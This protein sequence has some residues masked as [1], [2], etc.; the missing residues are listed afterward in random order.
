MQ[1]QLPKFKIFTASTLLMK[2]AYLI[3]VTAILFTSC[4]ER[5]YSGGGNHIP[6]LAKAKQV[7]FGGGFH[8]TNKASG[9]QVQ[10]AI[11]ASNRL[12]FMVNGHANTVNSRHTVN[13]IA[14]TDKSDAYYVEGATGFFIP[15]S[16]NI[17]ETY[18]GYGYGSI[19]NSFEDNFAA[20][21][22]NRIFLQPS[23]SILSP[24]GS[25]VFSFSLRLS[26]VNVQIANASSGNSNNVNDYYNLD[27][28]RKKPNLF[29]LEPSFQYR[30]GKKHQGM[31]Q[32]TM[33]RP[34][35]A[36]GY[37]YDGFN[38]GVGYYTSLN[39]K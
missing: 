24:G 38:I 34:V 2:Q 19:R 29:F 18:G 27:L 5:Y 21:R 22:Y 10:S 17:F 35:S 23:I 15:T 4:A 1:V 11:A 8:L 33:V 30:F 39:L 16:K 36:V 14:S 3:A 12:A 6:A 7:N 31:V 25:S 32:L 20:I 13:N 28:V 26:H 37:R 9:M